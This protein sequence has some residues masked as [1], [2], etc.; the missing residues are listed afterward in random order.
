MRR[1][2]PRPEVGLELPGQVHRRFEAVAFDWDGTAV[3]DRT[4]DAERVRTLVEALCD[5]GLDLL[6]VSG[7][8]VRNVDG[9][10][11]ARPNGPGQLHLLLNRGSE[12]FRVDRRGPHLVERRSATSEE[13]LALDGAARLTI[14][15]LAARGLRAQVV[16]HRLNRRKIDLIP[17]PGWADPPKARIAELLQAVQQRL[18]AASLGG[19]PEVVQIAET[20]AREAGL[21]DP[22]VTS[23][24]KHVEIG[25][26][27][28]SD[29]GRWIFSTLERLGIPT[30]GVLV[31]GDEFGS[32]GSLPGSDSLMLVPESEGAVAIT[33]GAEPEGVPDGVLSLGG[34]PATFLALL[35]DQL[36]RRRRSDVP[37]PHTDTTWTLAVDGVNLQLERV[38]E[39]LL[40][41]ADG[42]VG[43]SGTPLALYPSAS[44]SV[45]AA[46]IY[47][48]GGSE[49]ALLAC[50]VWTQLSLWID[51]EDD[52]GRVLDM[53][54]GL[55]YEETR[56]SLTTLRS[57]RFASLARPGLGVL[58]T[59]AAS[60][61]IE[62][63]PAPSL[64]P[65]LPGEQGR[66]DGIPW[67]RLETAEGG[68]A[69]A[70]GDSTSVMST[71]P[72]CSSAS[73]PTLPM[74]TAGPDARAPCAPSNRL[75]RPASSDCCASTA[76]HGRSGGRTPTSGS[77][78]TR[79]CSG[80]S[81]SRCSTSWDRS[82]TKAR[83]RSARADCPGTRTEV[84][85]SG[86]ATC[87]CCRSSP[88]RTRRQPARCSSTGSGGC[89][90]RGRS[91]TSSVAGAPGSRG[92][93]RIRG[94][95]SRRRPDATAWATYFRSAPV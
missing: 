20:A 72:T 55:L 92:S 58:R 8:H 53:R 75:P 49:S 47:D 32:L 63:V 1:Q 26:T 87:S 18:A 10:L 16:S 2:Q 61:P 39:R 3:P 73:P 77:R 94:S 15:R 68:V 25:L 57:V 64:P 31:A 60:A 65:G 95:T 86:T 90:R 78:A 48:G 40:T 12:V 41:L 83:P 80:R 21:P 17:E 70:V 29:S 45:L 79:T 62:A 89:R 34:G 74:R 14:E 22:R 35:D 88:P 93:R 43:T 56:T 85:C 13:N 67:A 33:V 19:L 11:G 42:R 50:P 52:I 6:I 76:P 28:K 54:S 38:H 81:G 46:G 7:T 5:A 51:E 66:I 36:A 84:T 91:R 69:T 71:A 82:R 27:D 37:E 24:A 30:E 59:Q 44:P 4:A 23:D 9:Q